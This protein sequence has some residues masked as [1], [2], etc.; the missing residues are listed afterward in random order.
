M[1]TIKFVKFRIPI[2]IGVEPGRPHSAGSDAADRLSLLVSNYA[3]ELV[4]DLGISAKV[5]VTVASASGRYSP[6]TPYS[7]SVNGQPCRLPVGGDGWDLDPSA[8]AAL[9]NLHLFENRTLLLSKAVVARTRKLW[10]LEPLLPAGRLQPFLEWLATHCLRVDRFPEGLDWNAGEA[11]VREIILRDAAG[12]TLLLGSAEPGEY[13]PLI[14]EAAAEHIE[15][16]IFDRYGLMLPPVKVERDPASVSGMRL[17]INHVRTPHQSTGDAAG[18]LEL[19]EHVYRGAAVLVTEDSVRLALN[20]VYDSFPRLV[21]TA[22]DRFPVSPLLTEI[23]RALLAEA[24]PI[25]DMRGV[26]EALLNVCGPTSADFELKIAFSSNAGMLCQVEAGEAL[27]T[28]EFADCVRAWLRA[29]IAQTYCQRTNEMTVHLV[30]SDVEGWIRAR[31]HEGP[32]QEER[33]KLVATVSA[34]LAPNGKDVP[35][36]LTTSGVRRTLR[37]FLER[38]FP[39]LVVLSYQELPNELSIVQASPISWP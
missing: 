23:A 27:G 19:R 34:A 29:A 24:V 18:C 31:R 26:L 5:Q 1:K 4:D 21:E 20:L 12:V 9:V 33:E 16:A 7:V 13:E 37:R 32:T 17:R 28:S 6:L 22:L 14:R 15:Q 25:S 2:E 35:V 39:N 3:Q 30:H 10:L 36:L 11:A 8:L 38:E